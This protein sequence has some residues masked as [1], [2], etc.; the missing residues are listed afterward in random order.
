M[1]RFTISNDAEPS[2]KVVVKDGEISIV[3][4]PNHAEEKIV[5]VDRII[6]KIVEKITD[7]PI[8]KIVY[9]DK[10]VEVIKEVTKIV[11]KPI[12]V[13]K[14][15]EVIVEKEVEKLK[16]IFIDKEIKVVPKWVWLLLLAETLTIILL[17]T[18]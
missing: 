11:E 9:I 13:L 17:A 3:S 12:E 10:P 7:R 18:L 6:E 16:E 14:H 15:V 1:G 2:E 8:E 5:Y 4:A